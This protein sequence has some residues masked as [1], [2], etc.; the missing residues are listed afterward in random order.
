MPLWNT[1]EGEYRKIL[2]KLFR[3]YL[4]TIFLMITSQFLTSS[5]V[6]LPL[7]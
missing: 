5:S 4:S 2:L 3:Q 7:A 1:V 6:N